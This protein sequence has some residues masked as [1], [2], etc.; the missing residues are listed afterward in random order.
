MIRAWIATMCRWPFWRWR[1]FFA[2]CANGSDGCS[3]GRRSRFGHANN[4]VTF[5]RLR[6]YT[7]E[8]MN[9]DLTLLRDY[10]RN[11]S[12]S[13]FA[14]LVSRHISLVFSVA[15]R[16]VCDPHLAEEI[17]QAVF[18]ILARKADAL[19]G[20]TIL[21][22]WLCRTARYVSAKALRT[23]RRRQQREQEAHSRPIPTLASKLFEISNL[24]FLCDMDSLHFFRFGVG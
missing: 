23:Q 6:G 5:S 22:G 11:Q 15:M 17:T 19:G 2:K 13:A 20:Q 8:T 10:S 7:G 4:L 14:E 21:P 18:I 16:Q 12:E 3:T 1:Q 9:D 24:H